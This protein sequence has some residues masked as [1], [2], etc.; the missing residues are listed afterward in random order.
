[1]RLHQFSKKEPC[2]YCGAPPPS[3]KEHAPPEMMFDGFDCDSI[4]VPACE[5]HN[6]SKSGRDRAIVTAISIL[7]YQVWKQDAND[8]NLTPNVIKAVKNLEPN[9][10]RAETEV[11]LRDFLVNPP[12]GLLNS[13]PYTKS[14]VN[15]ENWIRQLTAA[16]VWSAIGKY[17]SRIEWDKANAWSPT[18][19]QEG[20]KSYRGRKGSFIII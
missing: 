12:S 6:T 9:F 15:P 10:S 20:C 2:Y 4:T 14:S 11:G 8:R 19:Y 7:A 18:R 1:M 3:T 16:L 17:N 13:L 5:A